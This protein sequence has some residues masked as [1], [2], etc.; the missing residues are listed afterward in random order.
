MGIVLWIIALVFAIVMNAQTKVLW[1]CVFGVH[2][3][4]LDCVIQSDAVAAANFNY[5]GL[6]AFDCEAIPRKTFPNLLSS[7]QV[8]EMASMTKL[9]SN[10]I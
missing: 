5:L 6:S 2:L 8:K 3:A 4:Q 7:R 9:I 1:I 10:S